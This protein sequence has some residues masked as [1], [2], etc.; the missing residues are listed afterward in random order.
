MPLILVRNDITRM[1]VD[2]IVN[3]ANKSLRGGGGVD[4]AIHRAAGPGLLEECKR[5]GGCAV[6]EAKITGAYNLP[7]RYVIH[8][9]G[10]KW[11]GGIFGEKRKLADCYKNSLEL[12]LKNG[13]ETVAVAL[14]SSGTYRFPKE[15]ALNIAMDSIKAFLEVHDMTVYLVVFDKE[16]VSLGKEKYP[17]LQQFIDD[18]YAG[19]SYIERRMEDASFNVSQPIFPARASAPEVIRHSSSSSQTSDNCGKKEKKLKEKK[20]KEKKVKEKK[21]EKKLTHSSSGFGSAYPTASCPDPY[22]ETKPLDLS[23]P[24]YAL[25]ENRPG[26]SVPVNGVPAMPK[27][28]VPK[29]STP[30]ETSKKREYP[31]TE[32]PGAI[33]DKDGEVKGNTAASSDGFA[34]LLDGKIAES[35]MPEREV[36]KRSN[37][38]E[39]PFNNVTEPKVSAMSLE[40]MLK[41]IDVS[42]SEMLIR[43]V[44]EKGMTDVQCYKSANLDR[45][46]Y[47]KII[48]DRNY[49]PS[50]PTVLALAVALRLDIYETRDFLARAGFAL[51]R[52]SVFDVIIEYFIT[53]G[54]YDIFEIN[55]A[56]FEYDQCILGSSVA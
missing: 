28:A 1:C 3:A 30:C 15:T 36:L 2:A 24:T 50:K 11:M 20:P 33:G 46:L 22:F 47:N 5:L 54:I 16:S 38:E 8:T 49:R 45:R 32:R 23:R 44:D 48:N 19:A 25:N 26:E 34:E 42:F 10:P 53:N 43:K 41:L 21:A 29:Q 14:I 12:A 35:G 18:K 9:V 31:I 39:Q 37:I 56:L 52:S 51:S 17:G 13:C 55:A 27:V 40:E 4:G 6:G 7:S